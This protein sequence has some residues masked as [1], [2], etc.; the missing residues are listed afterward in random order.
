MGVRYDD[1]R[2]HYEMRYLYACREGRC[3]L[4]RMV[5]GLVGA[6]GQESRAWQQEATRYFCRL[7]IFV[8]LFWLG[9]VGHIFGLDLLD[10]EWSNRFFVSVCLWV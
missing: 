10:I 4:G 8:S 1:A 9:F 5:Y 2:C 3:P 6:K 7:K